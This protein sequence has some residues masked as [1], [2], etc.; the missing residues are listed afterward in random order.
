MTLLGQ[1]EA[2]SVKSNSEP[3]V[4]GKAAPKIKSEDAKLV[5]DQRP[6]EDEESSD[7]DDNENEVTTMH[8]YLCLFYMAPYTF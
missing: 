1:K 6:G 5:S 4:T 3:V 7:D 2:K 8:V